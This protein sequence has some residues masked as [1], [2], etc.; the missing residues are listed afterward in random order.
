M[1]ATILELNGS[2]LS[3]AVAS[4]YYGTSIALNEGGARVAVGV[5]EADVGGAT[6]DKLAFMTI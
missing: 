3:G 2:G 1:T 6:L 5:Y 4:D